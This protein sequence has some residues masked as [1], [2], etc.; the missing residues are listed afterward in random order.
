MIGKMMAVV[1]HAPKEY[2][3]DEIEVPQLGYGEVLI[4]VKSVAICGSDPKLFDG[5]M[6]PLWPREYPYISGHEFSGEIVEIG[7]GVT[8]FTL[9]DRVAGEGHLGCNHCENCEKG[10]YNLCL[11]YGKAEQ[12]HRHYGFLSQ[13]AFATYAAYNA[14]ALSILPESVS[15]DEAAMLDTATTA[16]N[17]IRLVGI[18]PGSTTAII[19]PGPIGLFALQFARSMGSKVIIIGRGARLEKAA[20][21]GAEMLVDITKENPV[22]AVNCLTNGRRCDQVIECVG[23]EDTIYQAVQMAK[24]GGKVVLLGMP[25]KLDAVLPVKT[26]IMDQIMVTGSRA[27]SNA[28]PTVLNMMASGAINAKT[29]ITHTFPLTQI[30]EAVDTFTT[31]KDGAIKVIVHP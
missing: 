26:M 8:N 21:L 12:G 5:I 17:G 31:R 27:S 25:A 13:G 30:K 11:N 6:R 15:Y 22:E 23:K 29:M 14:R 24:R 7:E 1:M 28:F 3:I 18:E 2:G 4:K 16:F 10:L 20:E 19:G 9:G